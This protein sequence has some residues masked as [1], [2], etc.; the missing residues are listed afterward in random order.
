M[1]LD[2]V[3]SL[4]EF[5]GDR[6]R[7]VIEEPR[8]FALLVLD[9]AGMLEPLAEVANLELEVDLLV[10][11]ELTCSLKQTFHVSFSSPSDAPRSGPF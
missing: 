6:V 5:H 8:P 9:E 3:L 11:Y 10:D 7:Q 4:L 1:N 2:E